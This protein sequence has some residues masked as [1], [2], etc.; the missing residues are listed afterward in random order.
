MSA[1]GGDARINR[2]SNVL[3]TRTGGEA[4]LVDEAGGNVHVVNHTA[5]RLWELCDGNPTVAQLVESMASAYGV[6]VDSVREDVQAI[7]RTF[8]DLGLLE[9]EPA[10]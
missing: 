8:S 3:V 4:L 6:T 1:T 9:L 5:A 7:V 2:R 10:S